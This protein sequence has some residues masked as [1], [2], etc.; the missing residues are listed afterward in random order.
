[1]KSGTIAGGPMQKK[2]S[3]LLVISCLAT[4]IPAVAFAKN[5]AGMR[6]APLAPVHF[7]DDGSVTKGTK[8]FATHAAWFNSDEFYQGGYKCAALPPPPVDYASASDCSL[9]GTT[10]KSEYNPGGGAAWQIP[11]VFHV[12]SNSSGTGNLSDSLIQ[13]QIDILNEDY[14]ALAGSN[15]EGGTD[16]AVQFVLASVDPDGNPTNGIDR[17]TNTSWF[18]DSGDYQS[19]L[20]WDPDHYM[21]IYTNTAS[22]A[23]GY[24]YFPQ[25]TAGQYY[26]GIVLLYSSVGRNS[27]SPPYDQGRTATHEVGH[28]LG[29]HHTFNGGCGSAASPYTTADLIADTNRDPDAHFGCSEATSTCSGGGPVPIH[30]YME[31]TDDLCMYE[32][33]PEQ[34]NRIR[35]SLTNY[36]PNLYM[37]VDANLPPH[38]AFS[39]TAN[40]LNVAFHDSSSDPEGSVVSWDWNFGDGATSTQQN[41]THDYAAQGS[42]TVT[43]KVYDDAG[44]SHQTA[45]AVDV[46]APPFADFSFKVDD[47]KV[48]FTD[49]STDNG[50]SVV[51]W[52]WD[53]GDG[54]QSTVQSPSHEYDDYGKYDVTLTVT[55]DFGEPA[56]ST[57]SIE[58]KNPADE[59]I[60]GCQCGV[61]PTRR[62]PI[63]GMAL[64][65]LALAGLVA[66][67]RRRA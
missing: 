47:L 15:G 63:S 32:F 16:V 34:M 48:T 31:Y 66:A 37:A 53:F 41:P 42:Y 11:V 29:L 51:G 28:Y 55:D 58:V 21:N 24:A 1:M 26:D 14:R 43:L 46:N 33:T 8:R 62:G 20:N 35:C 25:D 17:V 61:A 57:Q 52:H 30:N 54:G 10:I 6:H 7:N 67:R 65:L 13:S 19:Q 18:N 64:M 39:F 36:R 38:A 59:S 9:S 12:I 45:H 3:Q 2:L 60:I 56:S 50:G 40:G 44:N 23:L 27:G 4:A 49:A 5:D 22:G